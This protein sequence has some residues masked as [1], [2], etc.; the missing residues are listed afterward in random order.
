[1]TL[2]DS[3][4]ANSLQLHCYK[5][6]DIPVFGIA[7]NHISSM[8]ILLPLFFNSEHNVAKIMVEAYHVNNLKAK[9]LL[10]MDVI[11]NEGFCHDIGYRH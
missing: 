1:M 4:I 10:G 9:L 5:T 7:S 8:Y 6:Q 2:I 3:S 11:D